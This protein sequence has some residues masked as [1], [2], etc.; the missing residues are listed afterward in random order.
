MLA[1]ACT[2]S[3]AAPIEDVKS[4]GVFPHHQ[5]DT[6]TMTIYDGPRTT[7][8]LASRD[9]QRLQRQGSSPITAAFTGVGARADIARRGAWRPRPTFCAGANLNWMRR[10]ADY[11]RAEPGGRRQGSP[12]CCA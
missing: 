11:T 4:S 10:M 1:L 3:R 9:P 8:T 12:R 5:G 2:T 6:M 7:I